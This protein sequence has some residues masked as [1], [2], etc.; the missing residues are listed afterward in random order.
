MD[1]Q[2]KKAQRSK[3]FLKLGLSSPSGGGKTLGAL[4]IGIGLMNIKH[5]ELTPAERWNKIAIIDTENGSGELY[6]N[7]N[8]S[9][10]RIGEYSAVTLQPPFEVGKYTDAIELCAQGGIEVCILDS[11]THLWTGEGGLLEQQSAAT[12]RSGNSYTAWR[13]ITP[14][15]TRFVETMLQTPMHIIATMRSKQEYVQEKDEKSGKTT[16]RKLGLE[17]EMRKGMEYEFTTFFEIDESHTAFGSKDR[18]SLFDQ[19]YFRI[20]PKIGETLMEWL[21]SGVVKEPVVVATQQHKASKEDAM[22]AIKSEIITLLNE[23]GGSKNPDLKVMVMKYTPNGN[24]NSISDE[25]DLAKLKTELIDK[26]AQMA[27]KHEEVQEAVAVEE[28]VE[29]ITE[30]N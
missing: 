18:T 15:L 7:T 26:K 4:M 28:P 24:P 22:K 23:C 13:D 9:G 6:V 14:Q 25:N 29:T 16:V 20:E 30:T 5:P 12:K 21:D 10:A 17:P 11:L 8:Y 2:L 27:V 1:L 3:A 19:K